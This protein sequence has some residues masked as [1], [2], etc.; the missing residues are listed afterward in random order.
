[1]EEEGRKIKRHK[2]GVFRNTDRE[3]DGESKEGGETD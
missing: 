2:R 1:M 3:M